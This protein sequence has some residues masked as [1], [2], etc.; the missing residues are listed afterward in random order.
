MRS[1]G[2]C[3]F[4]CPTATSRNCWP[5][6]G[7]RPITS[8]SGG[9]CSA[10]RRRCS[11][12]CGNGSRQQTILG[13]SPGA[14]KPAFSLLLASLAHN[15]RLRSDP[16]DS[17][18][19]SV[20]ERGRGEG[21]YAAPLHSRSIRCDEL[22]LQSYAQTFASTTNLQHIQK[23]RLNLIPKVGH[24]LFW[25]SFDFP[26]DLQIVAGK[27]ELHNGKSDMFSGTGGRQTLPVAKG[28]MKAPR[29]AI[30]P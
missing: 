11:G 23:N 8:R 10:M 14:C 22:N 26:F 25:E 13:G 17:Q 2:T 27:G 7:F 19:P 15:R 21:P 28:G 5:N 4:H 16:Y 18:G 30:R 24:Y 1:D 6:A 9:G 3:V 12:A 20:R 29:C